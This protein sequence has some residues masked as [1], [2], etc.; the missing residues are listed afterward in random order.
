MR[1]LTA[2][3]GR[4]VFHEYL[5]TQPGEPAPEAQHRDDRFRTDH[6]HGSIARRSIMGTAVTLGAQAIKIA[7]Q[8]ATIVLLARLLSPAEFGLFAIVAAIMTIFELFK[9]LG[10]SSATVQRAD[11]TDRQ[12]S[13][14]FWMNGALGTGIAILLALSAPLLGWI[15]G[16]PVL[17]EITP[18]VALTLVLTGFSAQHLAILRRQMRFGTLAAIQTGAEIVAMAAALGAAAAGLGLWALVVQ[19]L[20]WAGVT[21]FGSW[22]ASRWMPG[23]PARFSEVRGLVVFGGNVTGAMVLGSCAGNLDKILIGW[24]WGAVPLGLFERAQKLILMPVQNINTPLATV[25]LP[26]LSRLVGEPARYRKAYFG[27]VERVGM[28][29][30]PLAA[31]VIVAAVPLVDVVLGSQWGEAAPILAWMG[32]TIVHMP[33]TYTL[34]W[35]YMSQNRTSEMLAAATVNSL[36]MLVVIAAALPFGPV[37]VAAALAVSGVVMRIPV[38]FWYAG[39]SGAVSRSDLWGLLVLPAAG[40]LAGS[41]AVTGV[42]RAPWSAEAS[43]V[44]VLIASA[45]AAVVAALAAYLVIPRG[46]RLVAETVRLPATMRVRYTT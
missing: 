24:F 40:T 7:A 21:M 46:R 32:V 18:I 6:L 35:L 41:A 26:M 27:I 44:V 39:R 37:A 10:L 30:A 23:R 22:A 3:T 33:V 4:T 1:R 14:L 5:M 20:T 9:D 36:L 15:Y 29:I 38:L 13:A 17:V 25:A 42:L 11:I 34:S 45:C 19:R 28:G 12:V 43:P 31:T 16:E 8:F 2:D